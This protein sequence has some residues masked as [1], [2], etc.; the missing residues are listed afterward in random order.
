MKKA[1]S[2]SAFFHITLTA[3]V[4][5]YQRFELS[6]RAELREGSRRNFDRFAGLRV[7]AGASFAL[8]F[9]ESAE[10][11]QF[12]FVAFFYG[13]FDGV[14]SAVEPFFRLGFGHSNFRRYLF[15]EFRFIHV[16]P[17]FGKSVVVLDEEHS[18]AG[19]NL[20]SIEN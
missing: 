1:L 18:I 16:F 11:N 14:E 3:I 8:S 20:P 4:L 17:P 19:S 2:S 6:S 7:A 5:A 9:Y 13:F 15:D 10:T 12:N